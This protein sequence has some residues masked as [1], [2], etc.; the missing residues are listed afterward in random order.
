MQEQ[1]QPRARLSPL[2]KAAQLRARAEQLEAQAAKQMRKDDARRKIII[3]GALIAEA[4]DNPSAA[5]FIAEIIA[6][7]VTK[8]LDVKAVEEWLQS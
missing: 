2:E 4:R 5:K 8:P 6:K 7:R 3:G 1:Q